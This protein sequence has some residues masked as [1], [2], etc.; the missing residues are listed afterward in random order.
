VNEFYGVAVDRVLIVS[1]NENPTKKK[2]FVALEIQSDS[3]WLSPKVVTDK[4]T[5]VSEIPAIRFSQRGDK[6]NAD[7]L[8][9]KN[10]GGGLYMGSITEGYFSGVT[11]VKDN[12]DQLKYGTFDQIKRT[13]KSE[14]DFIFVKYT[15]VEQSGLPRNNS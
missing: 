7:F 15:E 1:A 8:R 5:F 10:S 4:A 6:W 13:T 2:R 3:R 12:T 14:S 9:N 11:L